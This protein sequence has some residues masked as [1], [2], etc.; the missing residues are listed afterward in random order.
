MAHY[1]IN[2][3]AHI[4]HSYCNLKNTIIYLCSLTYLWCFKTCKPQWGLGT[5]LN[6]TTGTNISTMEGWYLVLQWPFPTKEWHQNAITPLLAASLV[7]Q[8]DN[9]EDDLDLFSL[10]AGLHEHEFRKSNQHEN[11]YFEN[12]CA[13]EIKQVAPVKE[14]GWLGLPVWGRTS[15]DRLPSSAHNWAQAW[16]QQNVCISVMIIFHKLKYCIH[17]PLNTLNEIYNYYAG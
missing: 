13:S 10:M 16:L 3:I 17:I 4:I 5:H 2:L 14:G 6:G 1:I 15:T 7:H 11:G 12:G 8:V 9:T